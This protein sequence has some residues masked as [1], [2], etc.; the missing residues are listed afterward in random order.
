M[1]PGC[2]CRRLVDI[3]V[4]GTNISTQCR[5]CRYHNSIFTF[6]Y[7]CSWVETAY[8]IGRSLITTKHPTIITT[9]SEGRYREYT[10]LSR[11]RAHGGTRI[12]TLAK[13][14]GY[15]GPYKFII[16]EVTEY[17]IQ[18]IQSTD[19]RPPKAEPGYCEYNVVDHYDEIADA[20]VA[21]ELIVNSD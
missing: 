20:K 5:R 17:P 21:Y 9:L 7:L 13:H 1:V 18:L 11:K 15:T 19:G 4:S 16:V 2:L 14:S 8:Q 10:E 6:F 3:L 12:I